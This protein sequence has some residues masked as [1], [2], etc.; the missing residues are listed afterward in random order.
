MTVAFGTRGDVEP[1]YALARHLLCY[2]K[3]FVRCIFVT[4]DVH[5][6]SF[7]WA[8]I[9]FVGASSSTIELG[10]TAVNIEPIILTLK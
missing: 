10:A 1:L 2:T 7:V 4:H 6:T 9:D 8:G 3:L 5:H